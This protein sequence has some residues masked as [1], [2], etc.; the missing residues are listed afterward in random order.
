V[1]IDSP[2]MDTYKNKFI[3]FNDEMYDESNINWKSITNNKA[4]YSPF[5][6]ANNANNANNNLHKND[7]YKKDKIDF[8]FPVALL[9][10]IDDYS[11]PKLGNN[12]NNTN[13]N[14]CT[15]A[16]GYNNEIKKSHYALNPSAK[17]LID[18]VNSLNLIASN[19]TNDDEMEL[20]MSNAVNDYFSQT[21]N[22]Y[23]KKIK[24]IGRKVKHK[25]RDNADVT[26]V[27]YNSNGQYK[28]N[29]KIVNYKN[30]KFEDNK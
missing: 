19:S 7:Y 22:D 3:V 27:K 6:N 13:K 2:N 16:I 8:V 12:N 1:P 21:Y 24:T 29:K 9:E 26:E 20:Y 10:P 15:S 25:C 30:M 14:R 28:F 23:T 17:K 4:K 5:H 18:Q 11:I